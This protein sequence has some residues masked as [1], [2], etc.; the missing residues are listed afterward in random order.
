MYPLQGYSAW[1]ENGKQCP[2]REIS[3][4]KQVLCHS[5]RILMNSSCIFTNRKRMLPLGVSPKTKNYLK[6]RN[7][8][9]ECENALSCQSESEAG[10]TGEKLACWQVKNCFALFP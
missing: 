10:K 8:A 9:D 3:I 7:L 1:F 2:N 5:L 4:T 6:I